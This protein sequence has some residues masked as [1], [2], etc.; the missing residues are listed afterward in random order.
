ML[1]GTPDKVQIVKTIIII[2][3]EKIQVESYY[4][5]IDLH[6]CTYMC[7]NSPFTFLSYIF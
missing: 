2:V 4:M 5:Y 7:S 6:P 1:T 3:I